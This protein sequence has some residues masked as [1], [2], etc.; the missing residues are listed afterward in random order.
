MTDPP[1]TKNAAVG[2]DHRHAA[3]DFWNKRRDTRSVHLEQPY[4]ALHGVKLVHRF[5]ARC[6]FGTV[7]PQ[8]ALRRLQDAGWTE[9]GHRPSG[10][11][12]LPGGLDALD[13]FDT[14][15]SCVNKNSSHRTVRRLRA[16]QELQS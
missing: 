4:C 13:Q 12:D 14:C 3:S 11:G 7:D 2:L 9:L 5:P 10:S 16:A 1:E 8:N 6:P 15:S